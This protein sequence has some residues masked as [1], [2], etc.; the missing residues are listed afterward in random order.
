[1]QARRGTGEGLTRTA[2]RS[3]PLTRIIRV[4]TTRKCIGDPLLACALIPITELNVLTNKNFK[5]GHFVDAARS[6]NRVTAI[7][8]ELKEDTD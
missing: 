5:L 7:S 6:F 4:A 1:M 2:T 8:N 3:T